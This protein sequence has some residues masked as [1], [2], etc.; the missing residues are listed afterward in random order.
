MVIQV[1]AQSKESAWLTQS[2][3]QKRGEERSSSCRCMFQGA[4]KPPIASELR[5]SPS[6]SPTG[7]LWMLPEFVQMIT[8]NPNQNHSKRGSSPL[9]GGGTRL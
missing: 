1:D 6:P 8:E 2:S 9:G 5:S 3:F 4:L 7:I